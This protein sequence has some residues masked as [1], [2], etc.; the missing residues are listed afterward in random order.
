[1]NFAELKKNVV[2]TFKLNFVK[3]LAFS[4][5]FWLFLTCKYNKQKIVEL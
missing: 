1:M 2:I 5:L 3:Y 4:D